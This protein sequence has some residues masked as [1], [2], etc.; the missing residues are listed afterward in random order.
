LP[1]RRDRAAGERRAADPA[2][3]GQPDE[4]TFEVTP[5]KVGDALYL[6]SQHQI[7]FALDAKTGHERWRH[8]PQLKSDPRF[9]HLT[10]RSTTGV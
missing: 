9:Q 10:C 3:E 6:C 4:T 7:L 1:A 5:I 8:D 2:T